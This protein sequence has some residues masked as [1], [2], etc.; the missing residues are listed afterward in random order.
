MTRP[1]S[2][3][4]ALDA[5]TLTGVLGVNFIFGPLVFRLH[6]GHPFGIGGILT[7]A[8]QDGT[9]WVTNFTLRYLFF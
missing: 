1:P 4:G 3:F 7:P 8:L 9:S 2:D 6:F 5:R